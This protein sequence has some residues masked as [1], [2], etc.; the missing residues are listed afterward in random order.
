MANTI[1]VID[2]EAACEQTAAISIPDKQ[3]N[4]LIAT[5]KPVAARIESHERY[6]AGLVIKTDAQA[7]EAAAMRD[8]ILA[9][10]ELAKTAIESFGDKLIERLF[11]LHRGWT[12]GRAK[13]TTPL[14][15]A[16]KLIKQ[17]VGDFEYAKEQAAEKERQR[18]QAEADAKARKEQERLE[19]KAA[20]M[21]TPEKQE[22]YR[23]QAQAIVAPVI[24]VPVAKTGTKFQ[25]RWKVKSFDLTAMGIPVAVQGYIELK[26]ANLER[27]K[28]AN[29]MLE[30]PGIV[31][32]KVRV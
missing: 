17:K 16:A 11:K 6:A 25:E 30:I 22:Q 26:T 3:R 28:A 4:E 8:T 15:A 13:F 18:L 2:I 29:S 10:N 14:E 7:T 12:A 9:D 19:A 5:L 20:S 24:T 31:F 23:E 21:K 1:P 27:A 32:H